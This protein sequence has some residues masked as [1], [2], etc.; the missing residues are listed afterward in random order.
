M[1]DQEKETIQLMEKK[2]S[3]LQDKVLHL[4]NNFETY[5]SKLG[6]QY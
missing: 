6:E 5:K 2:I 1:S 3:E 4:I